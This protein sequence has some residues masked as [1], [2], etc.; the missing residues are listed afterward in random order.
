[1]LAQTSLSAASAVI[2]SASYP[3]SAS[4]IVPDFKRDRNLP[5]SRLSCASPAASASWAGS[6]LASTSAWIFRPVGQSQLVERG[7]SNLHENRRMLQSRFGSPA[8]LEARPSLP[9]REG[10]LARPRQPFK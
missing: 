9:G 4:S 7:H 2:Q 3:R 8:V 5:A 1:M 10:G 6:P